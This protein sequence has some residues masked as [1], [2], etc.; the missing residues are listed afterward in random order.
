MARARARGRRLHPVLVAQV[1]ERQ[2]GLLRER[3]RRRAARRASGPRAASPSAVRRRAARAR[4][5][6]RTAARDRTRRHAAAE[7]SPPARPRRASATRRD[8]GARKL[9]T[10]SGISVAPAD[11]ND[12]TRRRPPRTPRTAARS[13]SAASTWAKIASACS[14]SVAPAA[15]GRTPRRSRTTSVAP[16]SASSRAIGL[17]DRRLRVG[18]RLRGGRERPARD[19]LREDPAGGR[20]SALANLILKMTNFISADSRQ[21]ECSRRKSA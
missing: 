17:R 20:D 1:G 4:R 3:V 15:V 5:G 6:T 7:R 2:R 19:H 9:A 12:A 16:V 14:T 8:A 11:G 18:Q 21:M 13:A 10:A